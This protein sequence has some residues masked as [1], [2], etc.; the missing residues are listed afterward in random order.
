MLSME[1]R[2]LLGLLND[3]LKREVNEYIGI[4][5]MDKDKKARVVHHIKT[6]KLNSSFYCHLDG[7]GKE[8]PQA[9]NRLRLLEERASLTWYVLHV[10]HFPDWHNSYFAMAPTA[11][12]IRA[13]ELH[14]E[15]LIIVR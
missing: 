6:I 13:F 10:H 4:S 14:I 12:G 5:E 2:Q 1:V 3:D 11:L 8:P 9:N 15:P 7:D